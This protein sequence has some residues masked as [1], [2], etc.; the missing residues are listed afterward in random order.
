MVSCWSRTETARMEVCGPGIAHRGMVHEL[1]GNM[2]RP[3]LFLPLILWVTSCFLPDSAGAQQPSAPY[4]FEWEVIAVDSIP[5]MATVRLYAKLVHPTDYLTSV[6]GWDG[7]EGRIETTTSFYQHPD[8]WATPNNN[9]PL[10]FVPLPELRWDSWVTIGIDVAPNGSAG[11]I[12]I[13]LFPPQTDFWVDDFE[14]GGNLVMDVDGA[15]FV[16]MGCTNG[17][18][19]E[20]LRVLVGQFTTDGVISG[21]LNLQVFSEGVASSDFMDDVH[22]VLIPQFDATGLSAIRSSGSLDW[23]MAPDGDGGHRH[24]VPEWVSRWILW[25]WQGRRLD[26]GE[27][28]NG[29]FDTRGSGILVLYSA[30]GEVLA[31][32]HLR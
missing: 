1:S 19:G 23:G 25:D 5:G 22:T 16:T 30:R 6:S 24:R 18:A 3:R 8:G 7:M 27:V 17:T 31:R 12:P 4:T 13:G 29:F 10:L 2:K 32:R 9:N 21:Y 20:D 14:A 11:E 26:A 28:S 15:W